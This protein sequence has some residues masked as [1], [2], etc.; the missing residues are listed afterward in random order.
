MITRDDLTIETGISNWGGL[1]VRISLPWRLIESNGWRP[2]VTCTF[3]L[4]HTE[5]LKS[6]PSHGWHV[7]QDRNWHGVLDVQAADAEAAIDEMIGYLNFLAIRD[8]VSEAMQGH[9]S[10]VTEALADFNQSLE[11][12]SHRDHTKE[13]PRFIAVVTAADAAFRAAIKEDADE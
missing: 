4:K 7:D 10:D 11:F 1:L 3:E 9:L 12:R 2:E 5:G 13:W 8:R 6:I